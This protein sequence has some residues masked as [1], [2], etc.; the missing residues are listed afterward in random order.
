[1][2]NRLALHHILT[3]QMR[4]DW[5]REENE[6]VRM[7]LINSREKVK[8]SLRSSQM[9]LQYQMPDTSRTYDNMVQRIHAT[10]KAVRNPRRPRR[11]VP[12]PVAPTPVAPP[13]EAPPLQ[14][15]LVSKHPKRSKSGRIK[16]GGN[17]SKLPDKSTGTKPGATTFDQHSRI[18]E[19]MQQKNVLETMLLQHKKL[20]RDRRTIALD[21]QRMRADLDRIR[22]K[23]DTSLQSLNSTRTLFS[24]GKKAAPKKAVTPQK[25]VASTASSS[26][27]RSGLKKKVRLMA[28]P[29]NRQSVLTTKA[30][31]L[32]RRVR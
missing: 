1:M 22:T 31:I 21:I 26:H 15:K 8:A 4:R 30:P 32:K 16:G 2:T 25:S 9:P 28:I 24:P 19:V 18:R 7:S 3:T 29:K 17:S 10:M 12:L 14:K 27:R 6:K 11:T 20:Q 13:V 23:L 5:E